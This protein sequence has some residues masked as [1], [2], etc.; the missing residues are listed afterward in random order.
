MRNEALKSPSQVLSIVFTL[1]TNG[2]VLGFLASTLQWVI[3]RFYKKNTRSW[4][5]TTTIG[6]SI[7]AGLGL[8][9][10]TA[11]SWSLARLL[12]MELLTGD[13]SNLSM[14]YPLA[15]SM[16]FSGVFIASLQW[17]SLQKILPSPNIKQ[18]TF[19][20]VGTTLAWGMAFWTAGWSYGAGLLAQNLAA[21]SVIGAI[22]G[23]N[24]ILL[25]SQNAK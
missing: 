17:F 13:T 23:V 7:G 6:Y 21:G 25:F 22:T 3:F 8:V 18:A 19:W 2:I 24:L 20:I 4:V 9:T 1:C 11:L 15:I 10:A 12:G 5:L 14:S 16:I